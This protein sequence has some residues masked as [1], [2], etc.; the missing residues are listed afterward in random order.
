VLGEFRGTGKPPRFL[1]RLRIL[2]LPLSPKL[3]D[4]VVPIGY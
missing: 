4:E 1:E 3:F 2:G